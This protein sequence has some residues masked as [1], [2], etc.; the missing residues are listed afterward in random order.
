MHSLWRGMYFAASWVSGD[1]DAHMVRRTLVML[2]ALP[3]LRSIDKFIKARSS[4]S[5]AREISSCPHILQAIYRPY[6]NRRWRCPQR[7]RSIETHYEILGQPRFRLLDIAWNE[8]FDLFETEVDGGRLRVA[9]DRP[10]WMRLEGQLAISLFLNVDRIYSVAFSMGGDESNTS[11]I[12]G[13]VQGFSDPNAAAVIKKLTKDLHGMRPRDYLL[14]VLK[15]LATE[16]AVSSIEAISNEGHRSN[17]RFSKAFKYADYNEIWQE[18]GGIRSGNGFYS[19]PIEYRRKPMTEIPAKKRSMYK[20]RYAHM[21]V[22][23]AYIR[24]VVSSGE[25]QVRVHEGS[26]DF[27]ALRLNP[28]LGS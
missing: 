4:Q 5:L 1:K 24:S 6:I 25:T 23:A 17:L 19:L 2:W 15:L 13:G 16:L 21:E 14:H 20:K 9:I 26:G 11:I 27:P 8:Y 18:H 7:L 28:P 3:H 10:D 22:A 12:I